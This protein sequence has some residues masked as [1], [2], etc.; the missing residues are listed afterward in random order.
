MKKVAGFLILVSLYLFIP[1]AFAELKIG[2]VPKTLTL[3]DKLGG[4]LDG[5]PWSS[6]SRP[7]GISARQPSTPRTCRWRSPRWTPAVRRSPG[8]RR[9]PAPL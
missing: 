4:R 9:P 2:E 5:S 8:I 1:Q 6:T 3:A 7:C